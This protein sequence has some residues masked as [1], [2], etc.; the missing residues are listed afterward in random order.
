MLDRSPG[1]DG[2]HPGERDGGGNRVSGELVGWI[3]FLAVLAGFAYVVVWL[4]GVYLRQKASFDRGRRLSGK[5][6][7]N[8]LG[9]PPSY[10][11]PLKRMKQAVT[12]AEAALHRVEAEGG[13]AARVL[14]PDLQSA[15]EELRTTLKKCQNLALSAQTIEQQMSLLEPGDH[16]HDRRRELESRRGPI[17]E[18]LRSYA[19]SAEDVALAATDA[20]IDEQLG[21][22]T[23]E[24]ARRTTDR[25]RSYVE[26]MRELS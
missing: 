19:R 13:Y 9:L 24:H 20:T 5:G 21:N 10:Q 6:L 2:G 16:E 11:Q 26:A 4:R 8:P 18:T 14:A 22:I 12:Q 23:T 7:L 3:I 17:L 1:G 15:I 25:L